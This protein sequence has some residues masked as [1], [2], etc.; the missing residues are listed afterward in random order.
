MAGELK[1]HFNSAQV[2]L[3]NECFLPHSLC[4]K[5]KK[6]KKKKRKKNKEQKKKR[7][8]RIKKIKIRK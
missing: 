8:K 1:L 4:S 2:L 7:T 5:K 3:R 6:K